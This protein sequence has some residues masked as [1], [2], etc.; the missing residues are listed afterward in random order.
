MNHRAINKRAVAAWCLYDWAN[1]AFPTVII[2][3]VFATYFTKALAP[4]PVR[5]TELWGLGASIAGLLVALG[6]PVLGAIADRGGRRKPWLAAFTGL[7]VL[8]SGLLWF[9][10]PGAD[11]MVAA[12]VLVGVAT[13]A[14]E[15]SQIMYNAMLK[16]LAPA[17]H[18][19]RIS[20]WGWGV[21][22]AGGLMCLI[23]A[24][25]AFVQ[26]P[27]WPTDAA[28]NVR[29][30]CL[31]V[32]VWFAVFSL[33]IFI[34]VP[35]QPAKNIK[36]GQAVRE[37]LAQLWHGLTFAAA[38]PAIWRF[39]LARMLYADGLATLFAFGGIYAAGTFGLTFEQILLFG[40]VLNV[41]AG[42]GALGFAWVDDGLGAKP[43]ILISLTAL[44]GLGTAL[45]L[46]EDT[47]LFWLLGAALGIFVGPAQAASRSLMTH[48]SPPE[49]AGEMFGLFAVSGRVTAFLGPLLFG[50]M[51]GAFASQRAGMAVVVGLLLAG[52]LILLTVRP[53]HRSAPASFG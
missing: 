28:Q 23:V 3:F 39:L 25:V 29:A 44:I 34:F 17:S 11:W 26:N 13:V 2:T 40:I 8:A 49:M 18:I 1:S 51:T 43:T 46:V 22:Y 38:R 53:P 30:T 31:L 21:G 6:G 5:G 19:G 15:F 47:T 45:L 10:A 52:A 33:P 36:T 20:G 14:E 9:A 16:T 50:L 4:D 35:D 27:L 48:L 42:L 32:A 37:G 12:L 24:L 7:C 41:T